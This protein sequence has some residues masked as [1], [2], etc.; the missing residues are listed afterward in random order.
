MGLWDIQW[1]ITTLGSLT[2]GHRNFQWISL[3]I[4]L[5]NYQ[6]PGPLDPASVRHML[7]ETICSGWSELDHLIGQ[8]WESRSI[9]LKVRWSMPPIGGVPRS[10]MEALL[11]KATARGIAVLTEKAVDLRN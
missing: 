6:T 10:Y 5:P 1:I 9:C 4:C 11:P 2:H 3:G 7:G 8:L